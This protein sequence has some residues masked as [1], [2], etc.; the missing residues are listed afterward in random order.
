M[1]QGEIWFV[2]FI[3]S[4]SVGH[5]YKKDRPVLIIQSDNQLRISNI[6]CV[7]PL[8]SSLDSKKEDD[9]LVE[10][11]GQNMLYYNSLL[12]VHHIQSFDRERFIKRIG[13]VNEDVMNK[14][15]KYLRKHFDL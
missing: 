7:I 11:D 4:E 3:D 9:I 14:V 2:H 1:K 12:K 13:A 8:S 15:K 5:E 10:K 6:I